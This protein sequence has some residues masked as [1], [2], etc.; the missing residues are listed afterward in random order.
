MSNCR[1]MPMQDGGMEGS[2]AK[3]SRG[4]RGITLSIVCFLLLMSG[5]GH[6]SA[7]DEAEQSTVYFSQNF[8]NQKA[9]TALLEAE[10]VNLT[11]AADPVNP[12]NMVRK[13]TYGDVM[14]NYSWQSYV[15]KE[16]RGC[17][18]LET[19]LMFEG[20][21][22]NIIYR[23][24]VRTSNEN[25][26]MDYEKGTMKNG[27]WYKVTVII[28]P[29]DGNFD[30]YRT[31][32]DGNVDM[33]KS[34]VL[35]LN[36]AGNVTIKDF[37][38]RIQ[39]KKKDAEVA[40]YSD[41]FKIYTV[42]SRQAY[43]SRV[44]EQA[45]ER[46]E[47]TIF[48]DSAAAEKLKNSVV[49][50]PGYRGLFENNVL[51][52]TD[53]D[54]KP[55]LVDGSVI[56]SAEMAERYLGGAAQETFMYNGV[57]YI[58]L[59]DA[60]Q[61]L[62]KNLLWDN[63]GTIVIYDKS[64]T[65]PETMS[66]EEFECVFNERYGIKH[67]EAPVSK[68]NINLE[69]PDDVQQRLARLREKDSPENIELLAKKLAS[70]LIRESDGLQRFFELIE[71]EKYQEA[72]KEFRNYY[73]DKFTLT[74]VNKKTN[75]GYSSGELRADEVAN[76]YFTYSGVTVKTNGPGSFNYSEMF[77]NFKNGDYIHPVAIMSL[78][79]NY[80]NE[81]SEG[82]LDILCEYLDDMAINSNYM[83]EFSPIFCSDQMASNGANVRKVAACFEKLLNGGMNRQSFPET[84]FA[85]IM[86]MT[87]ENYYPTTLEYLFSNTQNW[88]DIYIRDVV[89]MQDYFNEFI[90]AAEWMAKGRELL[91]IVGNLH[92]HPDGTGTENIIL[93]N[94]EYIKYNGVE[95]TYGTLKE[96]HPKLLS[97]AQENALLVN[98]T[99]R[100]RIFPTLLRNDGRM[101]MGYRNDWRVWNKTF[102]NEITSYVPFALEDPIIKETFD[103]LNKKTDAPPKYTSVRYSYGGYSLMRNGWSDD[104]Q[105]GFFFGG[106]QPGVSMSRSVRDNNTFSLAAFGRDLL[107]PADI[108]VYGA[109]KSI[110]LVDG[111][112][113]FAHAGLS[114]WGHRGG[115]INSENTPVDTRW[116]T[117]QSFDFTEGI[118]DGAWCDL[119]GRYDNIDTKALASYDYKYGTMHHRLVN[120]LREEGIWI[121]TD[122]VSSDEMHD[123]TQV[124]DIPAGTVRP[125]ATT[126]GYIAFPFDDIHVNQA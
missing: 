27:A 89:D 29:S 81:G 70:H 120:F 19:K 102:E 109:D 52:H 108:G 23:L 92:M 67:I 51:R 36:D 38:E 98:L 105:Y 11:V 20:S 85:R 124:W 10:G 115:L 84:T 118:Y 61:A 3:T 44:W 30:I 77:K 40:I 73:F 9:G 103:W 16:V 96:K 112:S 74:P 12:K 80:I 7:L 33:K 111:L 125:A 25:R 78:A 50:F 65:L 122:K 72:L 21:G 66:H 8:E 14:A 31:A 119:K 57:P 104:E 95:G 1:T 76:N 64:D 126:K 75:S 26:E 100:A 43:S 6:F 71:D 123:Y 106:S 63:S 49:I 86:M 53:Y 97:P 22:E 69:E 88:T 114:S 101:P 2:M 110:L 90:H 93:Y 37:N 107:S 28:D 79:N 34:G 5:T 47:K 117:S 121:V 116:H 62:G 45:K 54:T 99:K 68:K 58:K 4:F 55:V 32:P 42:E 56:I 83:D 82:Y 59:R 91:D 35:H 94:R 39:G 17:I 18:A 13:Q 46:R 87:A 60:A 41:E 24:Q 48:Y 113:S 15:F